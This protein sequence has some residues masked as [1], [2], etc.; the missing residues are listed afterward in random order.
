MLRIGLDTHHCAAG[1]LPR[2][3]ASPAYPRSVPVH[4]IHNSLHASR[5]AQNDRT[6]LLQSSIKPRCLCTFYGTGPDPK[7]S[8]G[9][10]PC[11]FKAA[12]ML[13]VPESSRPGTRQRGRRWH[14]CVRGRSYFIRAGY[15]GCTR[16][17]AQ[18]VRFETGRRAP[19]LRLPAQ[20]RSGGLDSLSKSPD[21]N[22]NS[23]VYPTAYPSVRIVCSS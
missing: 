21:T 9:S 3:P 12:S 14:R 2:S 15:D 13:P 11:P 23:Q 19:R 22:R 16:P 1:L 10:P 17:A 7:G 4:S 6:L 8:P 5:A 20:C 18:R